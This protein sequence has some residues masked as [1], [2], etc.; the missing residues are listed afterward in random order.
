MCSSDLPAQSAETFGALL[1]VLA[2][3]KK[4]EVA[5][6]QARL[7]KHIATDNPADQKMWEAVKPVM[8]SAGFNVPPLKDIAPLTKLKEV[9]L[10]DF[11]HRKA[12]TN[13]VIRVTPE[14][15][16]RPSL[17]Q[18]TDEFTRKIE[19]LK[20]M[21]LFRFLEYNELIRVLN[22]TE[23]NGYQINSTIIREGEPGDAMFILLT[24]KIRLERAGTVLTELAPG[25]HFGEMAL[26]DQS[27]R[28]ATV[29][30]RDP[31]RLLVV[32]RRSFYTLIRKE[33]VLAMKLLRKDLQKQH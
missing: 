17:L 25:Q 31:T 18:R 15:T 8:D 14:L 2:D 27:P 23:V 21:P 26:V 32:Q 12:K 20:R 30:A 28:S 13:E 1:R 29:T 24:G 5:G 4:L 19:A 16:A 9:M 33:P 11:L 6:S 10:K 22:V 3:E 7:P